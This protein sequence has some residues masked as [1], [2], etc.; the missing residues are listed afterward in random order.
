MSKCY[1]GG[2]FITFEGP[3]A[4]GKSTQIQ[5]LEKYLKS[6][7]FDV[8]STREP[9]GTRIGEELRTLVK[10][11]HDEDAPCDEAE[12]FMF[13]ASRAQLSRKVILPHLAEGGIVVCDRYA[14][15]TTAYQ[16]YGRGLDLE[17]IHHQHNTAVPRWPDLTL[18]L[19]VDPEESRKRH[20]VR[21]GQTPEN[22]RFEREALSFH[23]KVRNGYLELAKDN[24][25]RFVVIDASKD[26]QSVRMQIRQQVKLYLNGGTNPIIVDG[27]VQ[28]TG[29][30]FVD[31]KHA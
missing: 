4:C 24:P 2:L 7:E 30:K 29:L 26:I 23:K 18:L 21:V 20:A 11:V 9:G 5:Y 27:A 19:D 10:T 22:C 16:G 15:S 12:L 3:D 25:K 6:H 8:L 1:P 31:K 14:D 28:N 13:S 17:M